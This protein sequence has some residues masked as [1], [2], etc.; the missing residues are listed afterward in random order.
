MVAIE[1]PVNGNITIHHVGVIYGICLVA[2]ATGP[3]KVPGYP[4]TYEVN[5]CDPRHIAL[6]V[7]FILVHLL[8]CIAYPFLSVA[9]WIFDEERTLLSL[10]TATFV[11]LLLLITLVYA[12]EKQR[13]AM[14]CQM[15]EQK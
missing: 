14:I 15:K 12:Y 6:I 8:L 1:Y 11:A 5:L 10:L 7:L 3:G 9:L 2:N 13:T 4:W